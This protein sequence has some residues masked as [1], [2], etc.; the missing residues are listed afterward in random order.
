MTVRKGPR[1]KNK[2]NK[3]PYYIEFSNTYFLLAE[4]SANPSQTDQTTSTEIN[5]KLNAA[6]RCQDNMNKQINKYV[7]KARDNHASIINTA[8]NLADDE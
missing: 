5:F 7:I 2:S 8:I 1:L 4:F 3:N 6:V